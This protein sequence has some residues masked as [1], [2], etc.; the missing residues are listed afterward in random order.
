MLRHTKALWIAAALSIIFTSCATT[1]PSSEGQT[2][3]VTPAIKGN[4]A[5]LTVGDILEV[6]IPTIPSIGFDW[7]VQKLDTSI[8]IQTGNAVYSEDTS[9]NSAGGITTL[10]FQAVG[11]GKTNLTLIYAQSPS[12]NSQTFSKRSFGMAVEVK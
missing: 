7:Q 5:I 6:Q 12:S 9:P 8:L 4:S 11:I 10:R 2:I 3:I 1:D